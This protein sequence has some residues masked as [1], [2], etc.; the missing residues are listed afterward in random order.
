MIYQ[1]F[2]EPFILMNVPCFADSMGELL[3]EC[4]AVSFA[5]SGL[6]VSGATTAVLWITDGPSL[7]SPI[8]LDVRS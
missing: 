1:V 7:S 5:S 4:W 8:V 6:V 3:A 2:C